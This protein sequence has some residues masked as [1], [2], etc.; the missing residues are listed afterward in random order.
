MIQIYLKYKENLGKCYRYYSNRCQASNAI[1]VLVVK[2]I[3]IPQIVVKIVFKLF[4][5]NYFTDSFKIQSIWC[6]VPIKNYNFEINIFL[7]FRINYSRNWESNWMSPCSL[8]FV[9]ISP[10]VWNMCENLRYESVYFEELQNDQEYYWPTIYRA[11]K[12]VVSTIT[13]YIPYEY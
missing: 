3:K 5:L 9:F 13:S 2:Y 11:G 1:L 6:G 4:A 8:A 7:W 12:A 10:I